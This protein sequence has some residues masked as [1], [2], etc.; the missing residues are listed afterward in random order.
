MNTKKSYWPAAIIGALSLS[1]LVNGVILYF[2]LK[3]DRPLIEERPYEKG[4]S[5]QIRLDQE[6]RFLNQGWSVK[7]KIKNPPAGGQPIFF[8]EVLDKGQNPIHGLKIELT[9]LRPNSAVRDQKFKIQESAP[10]QYSA[11][12]SEISNGLWIFDFLFDQQGTISRYQ[13]RE[14]VQS[15]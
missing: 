13:I 4:L 9:A 3:T 12:I 5:Y 14:M 10:G 1:I 2:A 15:S 8:L 6:S 11:P 7:W